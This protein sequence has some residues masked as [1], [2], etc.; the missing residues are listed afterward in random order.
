MN[1]K[2]FDSEKALGYKQI[3]TF[4][5]DFGIAEF[6]GLNAVKDTYKNAFASWK[7][8]YKYLTELVMVLN[9]KIWEHYKTNEE[10]ANVY[11]SLYYKARTY[12]LDN[13]KGMEL[14]YY[15]KTTN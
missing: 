4:Y 14:D 15:L 10:L 9:W 5:S 13:L 2:V 7:Y 12:A 11:Q 8:D 3:T 1:I 6:F